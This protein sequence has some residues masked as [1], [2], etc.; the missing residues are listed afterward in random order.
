[1]CAALLCVY[2]MLHILYFPCSFFYFIFLFCYYK[3]VVAYAIALA[4]NGQW[5]G[6]MV[7]FLYTKNILKL[8]LETYQVN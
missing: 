7:G 4:S 8:N 5:E 1:M 2:L 3:S 6:N